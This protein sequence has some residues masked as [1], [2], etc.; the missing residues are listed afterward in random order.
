M[1]W[2]HAVPER[3]PIKGS[4]PPS[5]PRLTRLQRMQADGVKHIALPPVPPEA[6]YL[7]DCL[8]EVGPAS[9][10]GMADAP[11]SWDELR[12]WQQMVGIELSP[13][14]ARTVR[15]L[16][17]AYVAER[18]AATDPMRPAPW[19][20]AT[21]AARASVGRGLALNLRALAQAQRSGKEARP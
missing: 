6:A 3:K 11:V 18:T 13:W 9:V 12:T 10:N 1:G 4:A 20:G 5:G 8:L 21:D 19:A 2:L 16:S 17:R 15:Q 14:E 7:F